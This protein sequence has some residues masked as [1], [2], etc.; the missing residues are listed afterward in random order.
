MLAGLLLATAAWAQDEPAESEDA[1]AAEETA[2]EQAE[3]EAEE[4]DETGLDEQVYD[5]LDDDFRPSEEISTDQSIA[6][7]TDI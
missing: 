3:A 1:P 7:P 2:E 4:I 6:F 5:D